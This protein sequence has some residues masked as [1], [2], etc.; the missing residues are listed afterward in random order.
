MAHGAVFL[1]RPVARDATLETRR[2][3]ELYALATSA[4][5]WA[6]PAFRRSLPLFAQPITLP[7][8]DALVSAVVEAA[9]RLYP[10]LPRRQ[11][12]SLCGLAPW[13]YGGHGNASPWALGVSELMHG[14]LERDGAVWRLRPTDAKVRSPQ[15]VESA[16]TELC[17]PESWRWLVRYVPEHVW[18]SIADYHAG[19]GS[20]LG[21]T[22]VSARR[23]AQL[24]RGLAEVH[25][26]VVAGAPF[27]VVWGR[28]MR[29]AP[30]LVRGR[31]GRTS[32]EWAPSQA[33]RLTAAMLRIVVAAEIASSRYALGPH[34]L[35]ATDVALRGDTVPD[36]YSM[37][38]WA[39]TLRDVQSQ[40]VDEARLSCGPSGS[41]DPVAVILG[42]PPPERG[43]PSSCEAELLLRGLRHVRTLDRASAL[44]FDRLLS[45]YVR[46]Q[47]RT[48]RHLTQDGVE[49]GL[50]RFR[51]VFRRL[52]GLRAGDASDAFFEALESATT[53]ATLLSFEGRTS[54]DSRAA[55]RRL[56][57]R[58]LAAAS[59]ESND[60]PELGLVLHFGKSAPLPSDGAW[61]A[62]A[63]RRA[64]SEAADLIQLVDE[65][66]ESL[67]VLRGLDWCSEE[68][69]TPTW[70]LL[71]HLLR[72]R[73]ASIRAAAN[74]AVVGQQLRPLRVTV[75]AGED[76]DHLLQGMR[77]VHEPI[78]FG[79]L[80]AD[81]RIGH[82]LA[83]GH[84]PAAWARDNPSIVIPAC[85]RLA[86]LAWVRWLWRHDRLEL[87]DGHQA[88]IELEIVDRVRS[89]YPTLRL[90]EKHEAELLEA[91]EQSWLDRH[92]EHELERL[93]YPAESTRDCPRLG[94]KMLEDDLFAVTRPRPQDL[95]VRIETRRED[96][97]WLE[98]VQDHVRR[99]V[100]RLRITVEAI[101]TSNVM[102][103][104]LDIID[105]PALRL[106]PL[107]GTHDDRTV[108]VALGSDDP[109]VFASSL[110]D[111]YAH[112]E[113]ALL[114][115]GA[116]PRQV[117]EWLERARK[118]GLRARF[119][120]PRISR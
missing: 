110:A 44:R 86:D 116:T 45:Q 50:P 53:S 60:S 46:I 1:R 104:G 75:H 112:V 111:E 8:V 103:G 66:P 54:P 89:M 19:F 41:V 92:D 87:P 9:G 113:E 57:D 68:L 72:V 26:H 4:P 34:F 83:L 21:V 98:A 65:R 39:A 76:Y 18:S 29:L 3:D 10:S 31:R 27:R 117:D 28:L 58:V 100:A 47:T 17:R 33:E 55:N 80:R 20:A 61:H 14:L 93:G 2:R 94:S 36:V 74:S 118:N 7:D 85:E 96:A 119:T 25:L 48:Y 11:V 90:R 22:T 84:D 95:P 67:L 70:V 88:R 114:R 30:Q 59:T 97:V 12:E 24:R 109:L 5:V 115:H 56:V 42:L 62:T 77:R 91:V 13:M 6:E 102:I 81:D 79:L 35:E 38:E 49:R 69:S 63:W 78:L 16:Q 43:R 40:A 82:G 108:E 51:E 15:R 52:K 101:P 106:M 64:R 120:L 73:D 23:E 99:T 71:P 105:H 37:H 32:D 107:D